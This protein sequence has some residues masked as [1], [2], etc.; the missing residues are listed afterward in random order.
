[1]GVFLGTVGLLLHIMGV[2]LGSVLHVLEQSQPG[3]WSMQP[4]AQRYLQ[5]Y[6][7]WLG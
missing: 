7:T 6:L 5:G 1:M 2:F 3:Q 4:K